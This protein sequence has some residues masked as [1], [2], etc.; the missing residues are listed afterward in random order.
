MVEAMALGSIGDPGEDQTSDLRIR[1]SYTEQYRDIQ[2]Q[3]GILT[4]GTGQIRVVSI[5]YHNAA[6][7]LL[8]VHITHC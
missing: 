6:L 2:G 1:R 7:F 8:F 4:I 5:T 3:R